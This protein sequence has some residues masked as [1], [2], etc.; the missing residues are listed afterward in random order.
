MIK[1]VVLIEEKISSPLKLWCDC[2]LLN[3]RLLRT[4]VH[5]LNGRLLRA[6]KG[7]VVRQKRNF[8]MTYSNLGFLYFFSFPKDRILL[9]LKYE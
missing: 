6:N 2:S 3:M 9:E 4:I 7:R 1:V 8:V 5:Q